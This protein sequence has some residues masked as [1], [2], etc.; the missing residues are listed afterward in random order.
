MTRDVKEDGEVGA[1]KETVY[2][3]KREGEERG[4]TERERERE[5]TNR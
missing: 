4:G 3:L 2:A 1:G 5:R